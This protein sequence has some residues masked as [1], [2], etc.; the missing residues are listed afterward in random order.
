MTR[1][2]K[3]KD[4]RHDKRGIVKRHDKRDKV[5]RQKERPNKHIYE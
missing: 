5:K 3:S 1:E 4:K 2:T